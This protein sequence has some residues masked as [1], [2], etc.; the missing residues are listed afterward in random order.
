MKVT[1]PYKIIINIQEL[2]Y[3]FFLK[4]TF[5]FESITVDPLKNF[6]F[7]DSWNS[8]SRHRYEVVKKVNGF[9]FIR[10]GRRSCKG[11]YRKTATNMTTNKQKYCFHRNKFLI[12]GADSCQYF[13]VISISPCYI[14]C[15]YKIS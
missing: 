12:S 5:T 4:F 10:G 15:R 8:F 7:Y 9:H 1:F 2:I 13:P 6:L 14:L 11:R 3:I